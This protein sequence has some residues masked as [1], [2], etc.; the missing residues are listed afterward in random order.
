MRTPSATGTTPPQPGQINPWACSLG[1]PF[2]VVG[3]GSGVVD[4]V[5]GFEES[6]LA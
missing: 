2:A 3:L 4:M 5:M 1:L 6:I